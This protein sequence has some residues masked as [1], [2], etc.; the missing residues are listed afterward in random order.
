MVFSSYYKMKWQLFSAPTDK[1][2]HEAEKT[3]LPSS[4]LRAESRTA[5]Q[6]PVEVAI[7]PEKIEGTGG[8]KLFVDDVS[9][10]AGVSSDQLLVSRSVIYMSDMLG[11]RR[12]IAALDSVSSFSNFD[13]LYF[14][15][16]NRTNWGV[17]LYDNR[18]FYVTPSNQTGSALLDRRQLYRETGLVG[19]V[20][21]PFDRYHRID[22]G[23][24]YESRDFFFPVPVTV[25]G[26]PAY[27]YVPRRDNFPVIT[28]SFSGD[29]TI[30]RQWGPLSGRRY[31]VGV[32]YAPDMK[33]GGTLT[34][35]FTLDARQYLQLSSRTLLAA[36]VFAGYSTGSFPNFY[37]FGGL[38]T[39]RG[40]DFR[41][42]IG[43]Q[44]AFANLEFR[45]PLIDLL[46]TPV[47][48]L[49]QV[50]G[51]LFLDIGGA[52]FGGQPYKFIKGGRLVDGQASVGYGV[53]FDF[54]GLELHWDF[55]KRTD[56][57]TTNGKFR[58][59]FWVGETF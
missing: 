55:A 51:T 46:A 41:S 56:L 58:T 19:I 57:K 50:R 11:D 6:P 15:M 20:S 48:A 18:S 28:G 24:G 31:D 17:R 52:R 14:D 49:Q 42:I 5:F 21:Y 40:Y 47:F 35:D 53:S 26:V 39:L 59:E 4:P 9:V 34:N 44:A 36:R 30:F 2:L 16:R 45:F 7:D 3:T 33:G 22:G 8:F 38:N 54:M 23:L 12:F 32:S 29:T 10:N 1:P 25:N 27:Q 43:N 37:Y 13:F